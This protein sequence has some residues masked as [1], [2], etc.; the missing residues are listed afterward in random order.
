MTERTSFF[1]PAAVAGDTYNGHELTAGGKWVRT[2]ASD[3]S[4]SYKTAVTDT[5]DVRTS[6]VY[7]DG[8][9]LDN[10][11]EPAVVAGAFYEIALEDATG[12]ITEA[13]TFYAD[14]AGGGWDQKPS[15]STPD[16]SISYKTAETDAPDLRTANVYA[17]GVNLDNVPVPTVVA[18]SFYEVVLEGPTGAIVENRVFYADRAGATWDQ[19][20]AATSETIEIYNTLADLPDPTTLVV[21]TA[22]KVVNATPA[23]NSGNYIV[24]GA[25]VGSNGTAWVK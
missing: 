5:P 17:D 11:P 4:I 20:P 14:R 3:T 18:G 15:G 25:N 23:S 10:V 21:G 13:R 8:V 7:P 9:N 6:N 22:A 16:V 24:S 12:N 2:A 1:D 19:K